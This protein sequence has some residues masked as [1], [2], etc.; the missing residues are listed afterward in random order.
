MQELVQRR[1]H[2]YFYACSA[3]EKVT[4]TGGFFNKMAGYSEDG[5]Q[6][7]HQEDTGISWNFIS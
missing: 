5:T 4:V 7:E 1:I 2:I 6:I 3:K